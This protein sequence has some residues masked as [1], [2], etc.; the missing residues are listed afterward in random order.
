ML[1]IFNETKFLEQCFFFIYLATLIYPECRCA[2][3]SYMHNSACHCA[4]FFTSV[5]VSRCEERGNV[6]VW[7]DLVGEKI[8]NWQ[9]AQESIVYY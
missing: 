9:A 1:F 4:F 7:C 6:V 2:P 5:R 3:P 8:S